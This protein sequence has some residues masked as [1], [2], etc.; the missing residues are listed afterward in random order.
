M[1]RDRFAD[2][3]EE[4]VTTLAQAGDRSAWDFLA[5]KYRPLIRYQVRPYFMIGAEE[6]DLVQEGLIGLTEAI[7]DY[8]PAKGVKFRTFAT[9]VIRRHVY[10]AMEKAGR[11][12]HLPLNSYVSLQEILPGDSQQTVEEILED[13]DGLSPLEHV[14]DS[15]GMKEYLDH[16]SKVLSPLEQSILR[17]Y[18][19]GHSYRE[20]SAVTGRDV[21]S[22]D[23]AIQRIRKKLSH[24]R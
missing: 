6:E 20:I 3:T 8:V 19:E 24:K 17:S 18:L 14:I 22:V 5:E 2:M 15:E 7:R 11:L 12:K 13:T 9:L 4:A 23:N 1:E 10:S 21:K 16:I